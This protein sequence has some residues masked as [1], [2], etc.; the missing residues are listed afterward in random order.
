MTATT[1]AT[2]TMHDE[3]TLVKE[4]RVVLELQN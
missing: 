4:D 3:I 1:N 2:K